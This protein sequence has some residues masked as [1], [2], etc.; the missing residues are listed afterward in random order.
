MINSSKIEIRHKIYYEQ[1]IIFNTLNWLKCI[2]KLKGYQ[3]QYLTSIKNYYFIYF[4]FV[5]YSII[6]IFENSF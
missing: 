6:F 1:K 5:K 2:I 4:N 3:I